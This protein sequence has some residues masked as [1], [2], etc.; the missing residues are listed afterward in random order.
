MK[1]QRQ[2]AFSLLDTLVIIAVCV[3]LAAILLSARAKAVVQRI[4]CIINPN[5]CR[6]PFK[7]WVLDNGDKYPMGVLATNGG[8]AANINED[9]G[10]M[11]K[12]PPAIFLFEIFGTMSNE[13]ST[14]KL[15]ICPQDQRTAITNFNMQHPHWDGGAAAYDFCNVNLSYFVGLHGTEETPEMFLA[16]DRNIINTTVNGSATMPSLNGSGSGNNP[17]GN[18]S[19]SNV[20]GGSYWAMGTN[21]ASNAVTPAWTPSVM[22]TVCNVGLCDGSVQELS[23]SRLRMQLQTTQDE[24]P[25]NGS[26]GP[27]T[28]VFP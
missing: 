25:V 23:S 24:T 9:A 5:Q 10:F 27:N 11:G 4:N 6:L 16:G 21:F 22:H 13:L 7:T 1:K 12:D 15:L 28:L 26:V 3:I 18:S 17:Y 19:P 20:I 14:P 8:P 2:R